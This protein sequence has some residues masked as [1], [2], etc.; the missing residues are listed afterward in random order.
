MLDIRKKLTI[1][2]V[3]Q[4]YL[5]DI[6]NGGDVLVGQVFFTVEDGLNVCVQKDIWE[7]EI[8]ER[9]K[10]QIEEQIY[11]FEQDFKAMCQ[12]FSLTIEPRQDHVILS[13][14]VE[15]ISKENDELKEQL[16][17]LSKTVEDLKASL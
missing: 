1:Q 12:K 2:K 10:D 15:V 4:I 5:P 9:F 8:Y 13:E 16:N 11:L 14:K 3:L 7:K 6:I 17:A